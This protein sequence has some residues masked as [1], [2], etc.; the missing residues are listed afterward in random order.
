MIQLAG[1]GYRRLPLPLPFALESVNAYL[2]EG[3]GLAV[4]DCGLHTQTAERALLDGL[5]EAGLAP[6]DVKDVFV[7][8]LHP[9]HIGMAG[10]LERSGARVHMH[11][12][13][14]EA[15]RAMWFAGRGR[16][17]QAVEWFRLH[18]MPEGV[19]EGMVEAWL[20]AGRRVDRI[21]RI[22]ELRDGEVLEL[23]GRRFRVIWT[24]GHTDHHAVL[25]DLEERVLVAGDHLLPKITPNVGLYPFSREDPLGDFLGALERVCLLDVRRVLPAHGEPFDD[26][27]GRAREIIAHHRAR[28][29][30]V[31]EALSAGPRTAYAI[32]RVLFPV[33][34][35]AHEE[36]FAIA[37][38]LA[39]LRYLERRGEV[40]R[41]EDR[42]VHWK[43]PRDMRD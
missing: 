15:A 42:P 25:F 4:V 10:F 14:A 18:G 38:V 17:D 24:P 33:L 43:R 31:R 6:H 41:D 22:H 16:I 7:T 9:D 27:V 19:L 3:D 40:A 11:G 21:E 32:A 1:P 35:S 36:R 29:D 26:L 30:A 8:H 28:L 34:H 20:G 37:E 12:P 23:A 5:A 39:H 2:V 13:E